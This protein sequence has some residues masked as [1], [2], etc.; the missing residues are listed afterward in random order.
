MGD[1]VSPLPVFPVQV[2][3]SRLAVAANATAQANLVTASSTSVMANGSVN[4]HKVARPGSLLGF[5]VM[6][7][8]A[9]SA[10]TITLRFRKNGQQFGT[11][12][13]A[14]LD[15]TSTQTNLLVQGMGIDTFVAGDTIGVDVV[16]AGLSPTTLNLFIVLFI[17][18]E[19]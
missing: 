16:S 8:A 12:L 17:A 9:R 6:A 4:A 5:R 10:G 13:G 11:N 1:G 19:P 7:S 14:I 15:A 3:F 2:E 18:I